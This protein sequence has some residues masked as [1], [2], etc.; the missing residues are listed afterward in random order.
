MS[1][2]LVPLGEVTQFFN[3]KRVPVTKSDR[4]KGQYPY[5]GAAGIQGYV[6][7]FIFEG[8]YILVGEDGTVTNDSGNPIVQRAEGRFWVNNHAHV[9][10][11]NDD[12]DFDYL[13]Y[14]ISAASVGDLVTGAVQPKL[15]MTNLK[16][17]LL[18]WASDVEVRRAI[19]RML[20]AFDSR[21]ENNSSTAETLESIAQALFRSWFVVFD[22]VRAKMAGQKPV[23]MDDAT[24]ALFPDSMEESELGEIP[25][26]WTVAPASDLFDVGI[27][28]TPPRK[29]AQWFVNGG[30][31]VP[32]VSIRDMGTYSTFSGSTSED[33]TREAVEKH[34][35][36]RV[37]A[38]TV[39]MSFKLT[40]GK[41][42]I[43]SAELTTNEAIAHFK[44]TNH[45]PVD[46]IYT[47][48][49]LKNFDFK[50]LDS[51][52]SIA[53]ATNSKVVKQIRFL[54]P[55]RDVLEQFTKIVEPLFLQ[56]KSLQEQSESLVEIR[57][58]LLPR[59]ISGELQVP[60][61]LVA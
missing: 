16:Q 26:G 23:G 31:G 52:S 36:S 49:W 28:R 1:F 19:G 11:P 39:L 12:E 10:Q 6:S 56:L 25:A 18:P 4:V 55:S 41:L 7:D 24:A 54:V 44:L 5:Y 38:G 58:S 57:D 48:L 61:D 34:R 51:T 37:P 27:G 47:F 59:L 45:S 9:I 53:T 60:E 14:A 22:P 30:E 21:I 15:S 35:V 42:C 43:A 50:S 13:F 3:N 2:D 8:S 20:R 17:M 46:S 32:W 33:L 29:E 40:V